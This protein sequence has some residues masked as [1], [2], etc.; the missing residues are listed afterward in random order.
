MKIYIHKEI[1]IQKK[2]IYI[3]KNIHKKY[4]KIVYKRKNTYRKIQIQTNIH[5]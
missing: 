1:Y 2:D 3:I 4:R 5:M